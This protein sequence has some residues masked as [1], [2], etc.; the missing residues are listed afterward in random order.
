MV[1]RWGKV[2]LLLS[3]L[4]C[5]GLSASPRGAPELVVEPGLLTQ[6]EA[7]NILNRMQYLRNRFGIVPR[8]SLYRTVQDLTGE[9]LRTHYN[10]LVYGTLHFAS[11]LGEDVLYFVGLLDGGFFIPAVGVRLIEQ[12]IMDQEQAKEMA[13]LAEYTLKK[14]GLVTSLLRSTDYLY[15]LMT[16][17]RGPGKNPGKVAVREVQS[18]YSLFRILGSI[19][20]GLSLL[21]LMLHLLGNYKIHEGI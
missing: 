14:E 13:D 21:F 9:E 8:F 5:Q 2:G 3:C 1:N 16:R 10:R 20:M 6:K 7:Q 15:S 4:L 19:T 12:G 17:D 18:E 11:T